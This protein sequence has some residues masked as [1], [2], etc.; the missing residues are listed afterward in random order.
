MAIFWGI[1]GIRTQTVGT[2]D[3]SANLITHG[4]AYLIITEG[5]RKKVPKVPETQKIKPDSSAPQMSSWP[6]LNW[7]SLAIKLA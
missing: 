1:S 5:P 7:I 4:M 3:S 2:Q 6:K